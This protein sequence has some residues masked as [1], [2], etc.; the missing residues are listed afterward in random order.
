MPSGPLTERDIYRAI[1]AAGPNGRP[2]FAGRDLAGVSLA[3]H[4]LRRADF[5]GADL[6]GAD[7]HGARLDGCDFTGARLDHA[8]LVGAS[9]RNAWFK[10]ASLAGADLHDADLTGA[11]LGRADLATAKLRGAWF[12]CVEL[13]GTEL[14]D[15]WRQITRIHYAADRPYDRHDIVAAVRRDLAD[16][17]PDAALV[18]LARMLEVPVDAAR[19]ILEVLRTTPELAALTELLS[20]DLPPEI[21]AQVLRLTTPPSLAEIGPELARLAR[22][23]LATC[24]SLGLLRTMSRV[25]R[26]GGLEA[27]VLFRDLTGLGLQSLKTLAAFAV[28]QAGI[29]QET[30]RLADHGDLAGAAALLTLETHE[31]AFDH[32]VRTLWCLREAL[33]AR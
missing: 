16:D 5:L 8:N 29:F 12:G 6:R 13:S 11:F 9:L 25:V 2:S 28:E 22:E 21:H 27:V 33:Q 31:L 4:W 3:G 15:N 14:P 24:R 26:C 19:E 17:D 1:E 10:A 30:L 23:P 7:L 32:A 20:H 18:T